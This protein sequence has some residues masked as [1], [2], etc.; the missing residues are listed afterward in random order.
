V[1]DHDDD[2]V[3]DYPTPE[4]QPVAATGVTREVSI[5]WA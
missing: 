2:V 5:E 3:T 1:T 4:H